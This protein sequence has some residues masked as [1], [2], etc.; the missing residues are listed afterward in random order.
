MPPWK[1]ISPLRIALGLSPEIFLLT[2]PAD[3]AI[4]S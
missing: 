3:H 1:A 2:T 4:H